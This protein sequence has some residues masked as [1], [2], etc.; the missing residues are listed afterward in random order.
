MQFTYSDNHQ[1]YSE[2]IE[3]TPKEYVEL[4]NA[5]EHLAANGDIL[6]PDGNGDESDMLVPYSEPVFTTLADLKVRWTD[7]C[8][9]HRLEHVGFPWAAT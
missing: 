8:L 2:L 5:L 1:V 9:G 4:Q 3:L 6:N 7:G